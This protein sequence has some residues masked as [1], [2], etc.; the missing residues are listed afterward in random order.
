MSHFVGQSE[1]TQL[2]IFMQTIDKWFMDGIGI[3]STRSTPNQR[4]IAKNM[5]EVYTFLHDPD[6]NIE[7]EKWADT[8]RPLRTNFY[9]YSL[10]ANALW[11]Q[12]ASAVPLETR[13]YLFVK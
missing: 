6:T 1:K 13:Y 11:Q 7:S 4:N 12:A 10:E 8:I 9:G 3:I 2:L 5:Q